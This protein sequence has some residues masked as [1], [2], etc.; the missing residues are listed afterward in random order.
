[1]AVDTTLDGVAAELL[2]LLDAR[3][4]GLLG[5]VQQP[6]RVGID[7]SHRKSARGVRHPPVER[8]AHVDG[9][10]VAVAQAVG[11]R[12]AVHDHRVGRRADRARKAAVALEGGLA[13]LR[14]D[15]ALGGQVEVLRRDARTRLAAQH[16]QAARQHTT[17]VGHLLDLLGGLAEDH[18]SSLPADR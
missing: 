13:A 11:A 18:R 1:M 6:L 14:A 3:V 16:R 8:H 15:E 5:T 12:N 10:D 2:A 17:G 4:Q 7:A 9:D